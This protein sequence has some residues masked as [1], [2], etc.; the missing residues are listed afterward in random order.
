[1]GA[2]RGEILKTEKPQI[3][4]DKDSQRYPLLIAQGGQ[5][6]D[7]ECCVTGIRHPK[8]IEQGLIEY[9]DR[10]WKDRIFSEVAGA[11][12]TQIDKVFADLCEQLGI[13]YLDDYG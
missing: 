3:K 5:R 10:Q 7:G 12:M 2:R 13:P 1:M 4:F 11:N 8:L 6:K 9:V